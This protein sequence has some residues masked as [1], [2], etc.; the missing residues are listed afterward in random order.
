MLSR[1]CITAIHHLQRGRSGPIPTLG[2]GLNCEMLGGRGEA[3]LRRSLRSN[4]APNA[5]IG[6][7]CLWCGLETTRARGFPIVLNRMVRGRWVGVL[8]W[9]DLDSLNGVPLPSG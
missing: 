9:S 6:A 8:T 7:A 4:A 5:G 1:R 2:E 3:S